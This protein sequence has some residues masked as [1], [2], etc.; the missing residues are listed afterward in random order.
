MPTRPKTSPDELIDFGIALATEGG[1]DAVTIA[2]V[3]K[4]AGIKGPSIYKHFADRGSLLTAIEIK[5]LQGLEDRLRQAAG[6]TAKQK[7]I[8]MSRAYRNFGREA[9]RRYTMLYRDNVADLPALIEGHR[10][11]AMPL[12]EQMEA[13]GVS[14]KRL[15]PLARTLVAFLHGFVTMENAQAFHFGDGLDTAF[16]SGLETILREI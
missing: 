15:L 16:S 8:G 13:A 7:I 3:A 2:A 14:Q 5:I 1:I 11:A 12:F 6:R 4:A 10:S 9:P